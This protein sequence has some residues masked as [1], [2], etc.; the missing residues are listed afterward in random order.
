MEKAYRDYGA[1]LSNEITLIEAD[2]TRFFA[3]A[4]GDFRGRAATEAVRAAG[5]NTTLVYG[6]VAA[7]DCDIW[8]A[9]R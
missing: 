8:G 2:S 1:E 6:E 7:T 5:V 4:K 3:A 9:R